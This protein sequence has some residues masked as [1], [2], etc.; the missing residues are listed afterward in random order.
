MHQRLLLTVLLAILSGALACRSLTSTRPM[1]PLPSDRTFALGGSAT[2]SGGIQTGVYLYDNDVGT[3]YAALLGGALGTMRLASLG[4]FSL[5]LD[6]GFGA[7]T[8]SAAANPSLGPGG[9]VAARAWWTPDGPFA[10]GAEVATSAGA[11]ILSHRAPR[12]ESVW[13][14]PEVRAAAAW[15]ATESVWFTTRPGLLQQIGFGALTGA[16]DLYGWPYLDVPAGVVVDFGALRL[17]L[18]VGAAVTLFPLPLPSVRAGGVLAWL[19]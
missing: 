18:E 16:P 2:A 19:W 11:D 13:V 7:A 4:D 5:E 3:P 6:V 1:A 8:E 9:L 12:P 10:F 15:R 14:Q 17:G